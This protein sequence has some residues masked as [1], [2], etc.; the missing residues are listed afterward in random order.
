MLNQSLAN[1]YLLNADDVLIAVGSHWDEFALENGGGLVTSKHVQNRVLWDFVSGDQVKSEL[2]ELFDRCR[3]IQRDVETYYRCDSQQV[4][5]HCK[6]R[7]TSHNN[8]Y[9]LVENLLLRETAQSTTRQLISPTMRKP[10]DQCSI[11]CA[12]KIDTSWVEVR[13]DA[14]ANPA[15]VNQV[16]CS[17]CSAQLG[18]VVQTPQDNVVNL[19]FH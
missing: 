18:S 7:M 6:M 13:L 4:R 2:K 9:L 14:D 3:C 15:A 19:P 10:V 12:S 5:R 1:S 8:G 11:C 16:I 17:A